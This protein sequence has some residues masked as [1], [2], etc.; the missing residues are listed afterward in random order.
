MLEHRLENVAPG[1]H[2]CPIYSTPTNRLRV[3]VA[4][5]GGGLRHGE[6]CLY[7]AD[8]ERASEVI[9]SLRALGLAAGTELDRGGMLAVTTREQYVRAGHFEPQAMFDLQQALTE[10]AR[11]GGFSKLR[12]AC[13]MSWVLGPDI[14]N[15]RFLQYEALL[16]STPAALDRSIL[17]QYD[18]H[19][20]Q[21]AVVRDVLRTHPVAIIDD[22]VHDNL[23]YEPVDLVLDSRDAD[24][25]SVDWMVRRLETLTRREIALSDLARLTLDGAASGDPMRAA[26]ELIAAE[27]QLDHVQ[28]FEL[29]PSGDAMRLI[30][31]NGLDG[32]AIGS[33]EPLTPDCLFADAAL[34]AGEPVVIHNWQNEPRVKLPDTPVATSVGIVISVG[35]GEKVYGF[36]SAHS[37]PPR[38]FSD[39]EILFLEAVGYLLACAFAA[40]ASAQ[41]HRALVENA[42]DVIVRF[43]GNQRVVYANPAIERLTG[44]GAG[45]LTG[46]NSSAL[47]IRESLLPGWE[48]LLRQVWRTGREQ[49][50]ELV[51]PTPTGERVFDSRIVP[52]SGPDG[53][54]QSLLTISRDVTE[55][56]RVEA[57]RSTL[58]EQLVSHQNRVLE[59]MG[60]PGH[61]GDPTPERTAYAA[62]LEH[63]SNREREILRLVAAG[64]TNRQIGAE[65]GLSVGTVKNQVARIL[66]KLN[67]SDRTQAAVRAV[68]L[69]LVESAEEEVR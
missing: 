66:S 13:E 51:V 38:M 25:T 22:R 45:S 40:A 52:E 2:I 67:V 6:Q 1:A 12:I 49:S 41:S 16:N 50:Y 39:D 32:H 21:P 59:L 30:G 44:V 35:R 29:L 28:L 53:S 62:H 17:C 7:F 4:F 34:R 26:P 64:W 33:V 9:Q 47:G 42:L 68:L 5:F 36:L 69:G 48:L 56:R 31:R 60:R 20:T 15:K 43:D 54:V 61:S 3:L 63:I 8:P 10:H 65:L 19:R 55:Q 24:R 37:R 23:Y 46:K 27:L 18:W 58:Y 11:S 57:D 14:G